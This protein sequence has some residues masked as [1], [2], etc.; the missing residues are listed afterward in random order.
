M[1]DLNGEPAAGP[2]DVLDPTSTTVDMTGTVSMAWP[3]PF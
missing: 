3:A 2:P 1:S